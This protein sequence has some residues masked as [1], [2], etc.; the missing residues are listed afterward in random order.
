MQNY[1]ENMWCPLFLFQTRKTPS[2]QKNQNC[3][4]K[5]KF[6]TKTNL[7]NQNS[8]MKFTFSVFEYKYLP[9][10]NLVQ[11]FKI[12]C[13]KWNLIQRLIRIC[14]I[15]RWCLFYLFWTENSYLF[16]KFCPKNC[17]CQFTT[18]VWN[19]MLMQTFL[20]SRKRSK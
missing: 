2:G 16:G 10:A 8:M 18:Q 14:K 12:V 15:Q 4:F 17:N 9:W 19:D 6:D 7:N 20:W 1:V 5:L 11:K 13:S 3:Q